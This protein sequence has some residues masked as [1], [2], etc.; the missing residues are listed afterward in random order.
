MTNF[1]GLL[2][3]IIYLMVNLIVTLSY[4]INSTSSSPSSSSSS[5]GNQSDPSESYYNSPGP[6]LENLEDIEALS[7][8]LLSSH[9]QDK[10]RYNLNGDRFGGNKEETKWCNKNLTESSLFRFFEDLRSGNVDESGQF[11]RQINCEH[12][13]D[14]YLRLINNLT[15]NPS[16]ASSSSVTSS[17]LQSIVSTNQSPSSASLTSADRQRSKLILICR[18]VNKCQ[19]SDDLLNLIRKADLPSLTT[20][21]TTTTTAATDSE[22]DT[23]LR[24]SH[25]IVKLCP[26]ILFQLHDSKCSSK[27]AK[28][29]ASQPRPSIGS[30]WG[31]S[32]LFVTIISFCS[33]VGVMIMPFIDKD[34]FT[35]AMNLLEGLAVGSLIGSSIFHLIPQ[36]F[37]LVI[38]YPS[39]DFLWKALIIFGG[40][41]LFFWSERIMKIVSEFK[42]KKKL[43]S[44][45]V[46]TSSSPEHPTE[47]SN[48]ASGFNAMKHVYFRDMGDDDVSKSLTLANGN[49][50]E[51]E[52]HPNEDS[53]ET[54]FTSNQENQGNGKDEGNG[55]LDG[56][57]SGGG[58]G[59]G[60][61]GGGG[62][63]K[64]KVPNNPVGNHSMRKTS[65]SSASLNKHF[66]THIDTSS[67]NPGERDIATIAWMI[68]LGDGLHNFI[69][70]LSVGA[71]FSNS[72]LTG[73]ST[74]VAV[75]CEEFPHE[76][77]DFAVLISSG[78][79]L[80]QAIGY[81]FLSACTCYLG[82]ILGI[83]IG[84]FAAGST[85]IFALA[86]GMFLYIALVDMMA[87]LSA[88]LDEAMARS[89]S[90]MI[91]A[92]ILQNVGILSGV[93]TLFLLAKYSSHIN[94]E[95]LAPF[96]QSELPIAMTDTV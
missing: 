32:I 8:F 87:E 15:S 3:T 25:S 53:E 80:R 55:G 17:P 29:E 1:N 65:C 26:V 36:A 52:G 4:G 57:A 14:N 7:Y 79:T 81:N 67:S 24:L 48:L 40:I 59:G 89:T 96:D 88:S 39:H 71:A 45:Y 12:E 10:C 43:A 50:V 61:N 92:L 82:M 22:E 20:T 75:I 33:L 78:M 46:P 69:D 6:L 66:H 73:I 2:V 38:K 58:G 72:I 34:S 62:L 42:R 16:S 76:L 63:L 94:F 37:D 68:I 85:Y 23:G 84:D 60:L 70:G 35:N 31:F 27:L 56:N 47:S 91:K 18:A 77:G 74:S 41:Y 28:D 13:V 5:S 54:T 21:T 9:N 64:P 95:G 30:V 44:V 19:S 51:N 90:S 49:L 86:G 83:I 11:L 93:A